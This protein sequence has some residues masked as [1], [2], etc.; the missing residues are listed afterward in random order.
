MK[1]LASLVFAAVVL[2][3]TLSLAQQTLRPT[4]R[5]LPCDRSCKYMRCLSFCD[6]RARAAC[7]GA[8]SDRQYECLNHVKR[9]CQPACMRNFDD[10]RN[11]FR[12]QL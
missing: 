1:R 11:E 12:N 2:A 10:L 3:P 6:G 4:T 5:I 9:T 8:A 7:R